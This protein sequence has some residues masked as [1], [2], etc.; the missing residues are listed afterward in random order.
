MSQTTIFDAAHK[1]IKDHPT[2][3]SLAKIRRLV[4]PVEVPKGSEDEQ[5]FHLA[6][7]LEQGHYQDPETGALRPFITVGSLREEFKH[8]PSIS[9]LPNA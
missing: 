4:G 3:W 8:Y 2:A 1:I 6:E 7:P 5:E 9:V